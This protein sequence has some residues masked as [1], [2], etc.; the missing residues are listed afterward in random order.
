MLLLFLTSWE[1]SQCWGLVWSIVSAGSS[2]MEQQELELVLF[3]QW[4]QTKISLCQEIIGRLGHGHPH[5]IPA[6]YSCL[7]L[8]TRGEDFSFSKLWLKCIVLAPHPQ[9]RQT[10]C[11]PWLNIPHFS[12]TIWIIP[13]LMLLLWN[14]FISSFLAIPLVFALTFFFLAYLLV[15]QLKYQGYSWTNTNSTYWKVISAI[16]SFAYAWDLPLW[17]I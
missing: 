14:L 13:I 6:L 7:W 5:I 4:W 3:L 8:Y 12:S 2:W 15:L 16:N 1:H 10:G 9:Q 17:G 11:S